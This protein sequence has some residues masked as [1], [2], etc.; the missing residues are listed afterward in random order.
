MNSSRR[1]ETGISYVEVMLAMLVLMVGLLAL[2]A[3]MTAG[4]VKTRL[5]E[6]QLRAKQY[7]T[8]AIESILSARDVMLAN[9]SLNF[10]LI[11][12]EGNGGVFLDDEQPVYTLAGPDGFIGTED[13]DGEIVEGFTRT[14]EFTDLADPNRPSPPNPITMR[15]VLVTITYQDNDVE[16]TERMT[17]YVTDFAN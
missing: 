4:V 7:A 14:I 13:D 12:N 1:R 16:R 11:Q 5:S 9:D 6:Q 8:S 3:A 2:A 15:R 17:S 10:A